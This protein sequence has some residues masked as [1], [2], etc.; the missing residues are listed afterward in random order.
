MGGLLNSSVALTLT[1]DALREDLYRV[2]ACHA[3]WSLV[4]KS[5]MRVGGKMGIEVN[6]Q[7]HRHD[8]IYMR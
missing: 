7:H 4:T 2:L 8:A 1:V 6:P 5:T 3:P